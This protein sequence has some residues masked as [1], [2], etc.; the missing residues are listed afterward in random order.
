MNLDKVKLT[1]GEIIG[2]ADLR[3]KGINI[4]SWGSFINHNGAL[5]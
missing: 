4:C 5:F 3:F 1:G 2:M